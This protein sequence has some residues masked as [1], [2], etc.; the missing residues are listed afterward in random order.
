[1]LGF[2]G[3]VVRLKLRYEHGAP[4]PGRSMIGKFAAPLASARELL[5]DFGGYQRE[6]RFYAELAGNTGLPAPACY[7]H[8]YDSRNG[9]FVLLLEDLA[10]SRLGDQVTGASYEEAEF[11]V[12]H[13]ARFHAR[14]W[15]DASLLELPW[16]QPSRAAI[17]KLPDL[18]ERGLGPLRETM[19]GRF[20]DVMRLVQR[21]RPLVPELAQMYGSQFPPR[22][23]TLVH[24]DM[25]MDN[26][27]FPV[28]GRGRFA[29]VD[30]QGA[31]IGSPGNELAYFLILSLPVAVRRQHEASLIARYHS[32]L[33]AYGVRDYP[34]QAL[35]RD[36]DRGIL[37]QLLGLPV[38]SGNLDF[39]SER[40]QALATAALE[41]LSAAAADLKAARIITV[42][43][44]VLRLQR[45]GRAIRRRLPSMRRR[46]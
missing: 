15:N 6:V 3:R 31:A 16:A 44:W 28:E 24:G 14:W 32:E 7:Y 20:E 38:L 26:L 41:R 30:W 46:G 34:L 2:A 29:V 37:I 22:P 18:F 19:T 39:S 21:L 40:G 35:K 23:Y 17:E 10:A 1:G 4:E 13:L 36:Y 33:V 8:A 42:L 43:T 5:N 9:T 25:R 12:S 45:L 11:V 27:F